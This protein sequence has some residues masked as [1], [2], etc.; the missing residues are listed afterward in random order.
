MLILLKEVVALGTTNFVTKFCPFFLMKGTSNTHV[1]Y[2]K[3]A[4]NTSKINDFSLIYALNTPKINY[5]YVAK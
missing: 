2:K 1:F 4:L 5:L 3:H